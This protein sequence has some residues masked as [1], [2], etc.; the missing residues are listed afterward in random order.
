M[1]LISS[2]M[3]Q[4]LHVPTIPSSWNYIV[5]LYADDILLVT[6][7]ITELQRLFDACQRE[8]CWLDMRINEKKSCCIRIGPRCDT[9]SMCLYNYNDGHK[10]PWV[11]EI[12]YLGVHITQSRKFRCSLNHDKQSFYRSLNAVLGKIG[13]TASEEDIFELV[14]S[15]CLY[16]FYYMAWNVSLSMPVI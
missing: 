10:L 7:S 13:R 2:V 15:K 4:I 1:I 3:A 14:K 16:R 5:V 9:C 6:F 12:R 11:K 8:L